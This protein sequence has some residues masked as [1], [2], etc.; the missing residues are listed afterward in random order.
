MVRL[1]A[2]G[3]T[4]IRRRPEAEKGA[5]P[6]FSTYSAGTAYRSGVVG[7]EY[8]DI[9]FH[10]TYQQFFRCIKSYP[11][12]ETHEPSQ[13]A[14]TLWWE[15]M[16]GYEHVVANMLLSNSAFINQL[17]VNQLL[18]VGGGFATEITPG[19]FQLKYNGSVVAFFE[20]QSDGTVALKFIGSDGEWCSIGSSGLKYSDI[21]AEDYRWDEVQYAQFSS[22]DRETISNYLNNPSRYS[23]IGFTA[24]T[25]ETFYQYHCASK[26]IS[27]VTKYWN[28]DAGSYD[29][30]AA[31]LSTRPWQ[32]GKLFTSRSVRTADLLNLPYSIYSEYPNGI[33]ALPYDPNVTPATNYHVFNFPLYT[34]TNGVY[35]NT[36]SVFQGIVHTPYVNRYSLKA[37]DR[38]E[39]SN[40]DTSEW[41]K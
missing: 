5:K 21:S 19:S 41:E 18:S 37:G 17:V 30:E 27:G 34:V 40:I 28:P 16:Q 3:H 25:F 35:S 23:G 8:Y 20:V 9:V 11:A 22:A 13:G 12:S 2:Q 24:P 14:S 1:A 36:G 38:L 15:Y 4:V 26:T 31:W 7:E 39:T 32:H 29:T 6:W 33:N 10:E